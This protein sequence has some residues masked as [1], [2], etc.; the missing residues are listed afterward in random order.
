MMMERILTDK[1]EKE[2]ALLTNV[3]YMLMTAA[4]Q[5]LYRTEEYF[6]AMGVAMVGKKKV[7]HRNMMSHYN[8]MKQMMDSVEKDYV[9]SFGEDFW[10]KFDEI[11]ASGAY[12]ARLA[13][14]V[15]DRCRS[16]EVEGE[17]ERGIESYVHNMPAG[18]CCDDE[19]LKR[20]FLR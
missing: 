12:F 19:F 11:R 3:Y 5:V 14:L 9:E 4:D 18:G 17:R 15:A 2:L 20:F 13:V 10:K 1:Q 16:E 7:R 6:A 8:T